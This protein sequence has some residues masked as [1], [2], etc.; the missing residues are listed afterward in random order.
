VTWPERLL[1]QNA[2]LRRIG[3]WNWSIPAHVV[4]LSDGSLFNTCPCAGVCARVCY[5]KF[6]TYRFRNVLARHTLNLEYVLTEP[7][8]WQQQMIAEVGHRR[9][10][11][12]GKP[13]NLEHDPA[14]RWL[15]EWAMLGGKAV[16]IH[17]AGDFFARW[18]LDRW[19]QIAESRPDALFYAYSKEVALL[20]DAGLPRN[21][22]VLFSFGGTQDHLIDRTMHRH[23]DV[24]PDEQTLLKHHYIDQGES[25]LMAVV[26]PSNRIGIIANNIAVAN[27]RFAGR[28]M[29]SYQVEVRR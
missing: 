15:H 9:F 29:S 12:T 6:N 2:E 5:A 28:S 24:F 19:C 14:D 16:R 20:L 23:A 25:D 8:A 4:R 22:R 27:K 10:N 7:D 21:L 26:H 17:D 13:H 11:V 18:Y 1:S 3:V